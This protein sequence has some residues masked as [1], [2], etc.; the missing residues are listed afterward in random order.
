MEWDNFAAIPVDTYDNWWSRQINDKTRNLVRKSIKKGVVVKEAVYDDEFVRGIVNIYNESPIRQGKPFWH[1]GKSFDA[2]K[3]ENASY[4]DRSCFL[5]AYFNEE[6]I[7]FLKLVFNGST[8]TVMQILGMIQHRDKSTTNA[9]INSAVKKCETSNIKYLIYAKHTY[10][11]KGT[12]KLSSFKE[13]NGFLK[14]E[15]PRYFVPLNAYGNAFLRLNLHKDISEFIPEKVLQY[16]LN[17]REKYYKQ[18]YGI[19]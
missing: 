16:I 14:Y 15:Y 6:L 17:I 9:L 19:Q 10:G 1:Y 18:K 12:D 13:H 2:V 4:P 7:G 11:K 3:M 5:G 8:A